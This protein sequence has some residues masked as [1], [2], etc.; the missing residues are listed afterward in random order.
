[1]LETANVSPFG[2]PSRQN[3]KDIPCRKRFQIGQAE[4]SRDF[5][6]TWWTATAR[7]NLPHV[8][9]RPKMA[10]V[11]RARPIRPVRPPCRCPEQ[12]EA[13]LMSQSSIC[14]KSRLAFFL[15]AAATS[16]F[17]WLATDGAEL[18]VGTG[19]TVITPILSSPMAGYFFER[20]GRGRARRAD[21]QG[22]PCSAS[23]AGWS[24]WSPA[25]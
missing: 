18:T 6:S 5:P 7:H 17:G 20:P 2:R 4:E 15:A 10:S 3:S 14:R 11:C 21:G 1:M 13:I 12:S 25:T 23:R 16:V 8:W 9:R 24:G 19:K 22:N